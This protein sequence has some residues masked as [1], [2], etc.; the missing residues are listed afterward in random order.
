M[1]IGWIEIVKRRRYGGS[2][3][4]KLTQGIISITASNGDGGN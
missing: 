3:C 1:K 2:I 4:D